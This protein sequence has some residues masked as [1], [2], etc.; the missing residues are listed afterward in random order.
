MLTVVETPTFQKLWPNYWA[1]EERGEFAAYISEHP[2]AGDLVQKSG[3]VRKVRWS[4]VGSGKSSGV[5][6]VYFNRTKRGEVVLL[7][8]YAKA[9]LD[10]ISGETLK[11]LRNAAEKADE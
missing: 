7:L 10:S 4:R 6:V 5:R 11:E 2:D 3:G 9:N 8:I 1:E